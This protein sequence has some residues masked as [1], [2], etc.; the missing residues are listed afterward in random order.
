MTESKKQKYLRPLHLLENGFLVIPE[1]IKELVDASN[2]LLARKLYAQSL[3]LS[4]IALEECGKLFL[5]DSLLF[6]RDKNKDNF[7]RSSIS[8]HNKLDA[9]IFTIG[10]LKLISQFD[11]RSEDEKTKFKFRKAIQIGLFNLHEKYKE[12][13]DDLPGNDIR[14]LDRL[15]QNGFYSKFH[16]QK[17][18]KPSKEVDKVLSKKVNELI[19]LFQK[20]IQF[21][22]NPQAVSGYT[23]FAKTVRSK[24]GKDEWSEID[25]FTEEYVEDFLSELQKPTLH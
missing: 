12:V 5:L 4:I 11:N 18:E 21:I 24:I 6:V 14:A 17:F 20:N 10:L 19:N 15:K 25:E 1:T 9:S 16:N 23:A 22:M 7:N 13:R 3:S 2:A 8:H